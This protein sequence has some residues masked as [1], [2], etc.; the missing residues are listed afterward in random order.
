M[1]HCQSELLLKRW[2]FKDCLKML[3]EIAGSRSCGG[4]AF[5]DNGLDEENM[6][7]IHY[8]C[9]AVDV[10]GYC[11]VSWTISLTSISSVSSVVSTSSSGSSVTRADCRLSAEWMTTRRNS[12]LVYVLALYIDRRIVWLVC[13]FAGLTC[14]SNRP[15]SLSALLQSSSIASRANPLECRYNYII[16]RA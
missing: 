6:L 4:R 2:V 1:T 15:T 5:Q 13:R 3:M 10:H 7:C 9:F 14:C 11:R 16:E 12:Y 8:G